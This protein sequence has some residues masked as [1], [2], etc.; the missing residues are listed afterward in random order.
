MANFRNRIVRPTKRQMVW[1][2]I[3]SGTAPVSI[4]AAG[5]TLLGVLNAAALAL[6]PFTIVRI[7]GLI[8]YESDQ[9]AASELPFGIISEQVVT[10]QASAAGIA[11]LL[12]PLTEPDGDFF[13]YEPVASTFELGDATGFTTSNSNSRLFDSKAQRKV[14]A[15]QD[16]VLVGE[17]ES[18]VGA[19]VVV[20]GR[21]L[22]KLH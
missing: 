16:V 7:R 1:I 13:M 12:T 8:N 11:S 22:V 3:S 17:N 15:N 2:G 19:L 10:E 5:T 20:I 6:R 21:M 14:G 18:L 9:S 4:A